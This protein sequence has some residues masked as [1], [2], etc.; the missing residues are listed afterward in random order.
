VGGVG[1]GRRGVGHPC[2]KK[3]SLA[4]LVGGLVCQGASG[5]RETMVV[6][7]CQMVVAALVLYGSAATAVAFTAPLLPRPKW[8]SAA[9]SRAAFRTVHCGN[10]RRRGVRSAPVAAVD[11]GDTKPIYLDYSGTTPVDSRVIDAMLPYFRDGWGKRWE[12]GARHPSRGIALGRAD[13]RV[14]L[15]SVRRKPLELSLLWA[16]GKGGPG[17]R[18]TAGCGE[19]RMFARRNFFHERRDGSQ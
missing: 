15:L 14:Q 5:N 6:S 3:R 17:A 9:E 16:I 8:L 13:M 12:I 4:P 7:R 10:H 11:G 1:Q 2:R 19:H 18:E